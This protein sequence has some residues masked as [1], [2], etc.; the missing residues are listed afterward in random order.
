MSGLPEIDYYD[1]NVYIKINL[2]EYNERFI[3]AQQWLGDRVLEDCKPLMPLLTGSL[4]QRSRVEEG[5]KMVVFPGPYARYLYYGVKMVDSVSGK[6]PRKIP[7]APG[8]TILRFCK[9]AKLVPTNIP[10]TYARTEAVPE[11]FEVAKK[12]NLQYWTD[13]AAKIIGG[14]K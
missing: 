3:N 8:E 5:G 11:W 10:L 9:G 7:T 13:G 12:K 4:Q 2:S 1:G 6:G 14:K